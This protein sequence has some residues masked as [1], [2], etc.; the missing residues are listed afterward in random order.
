MR[1][2]AQLVF[3]SLLLCGCGKND[4]VNDQTGVEATLPVEVP[5][6]PLGESLIRRIAFGSCLGQDGVQPIWDH[7]LAAQPDVFVFLGDNIYSDTADPVVLQAEYAKLGAQPGLQRLRQQSH[8]MATWDDHDYGTNNSG[9]DFPA[10]EMS[11]QTF[12]DFWEVAKDSPRRQLDGVYSAE[13]FGPPGKRVQI[14]LL[15]TRYNRSPLVYQENPDDPKL[16]GHYVPST[17]PQATLLGSQ[18]WAW[19]EAQLLVPAQIRIIGSSIQVVNEDSGGETW[20]NFPLERQRFFDLLWRST[21]SF[22]ISGDVHYA[23]LSMMDGN[24]GYP[25]YDLTS[26][27]LNWSERVYRMPKRNRHRLAVEMRGDNFGL[28]EID[29]SRSDPLIRFKIIDVDGD[30]MIH[31]KV[32]LSVLRESNLTWWNAGANSPDEPQ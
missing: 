22:F 4:P 28:I 5:G 23:E 14:I 20:A 29:W 16:G 8:I 27:S 31:H 15:D 11:K 24:A 30:V 26:S 17:D 9:G 10:K 13:V 6:E 19:L 21:G 3:L 12:L 18:Q 2:S 7:V 32:E 25:I 1:H